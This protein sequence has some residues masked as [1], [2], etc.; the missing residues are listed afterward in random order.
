MPNNAIPK[1]EWLHCNACARSTDHTLLHVHRNKD[2]VEDILDEQGNR[3]DRVHGYN[4]WQLFECQG[5]KTVFL[6]LKEY[7]S[8][9]H[10]AWDDDPYK[11]TSFPARNVGARPKPYW[12]ETLSELD[13]LQGHFIL[14][15]YE[16]IYQLIE[17]QNYLAALLTS[18][19][20]L[21]TIAVE[22]GSG[23][24]RTFNEKLQALNEND[25]IRKSQ[26]AFL[27][28]A[29]YDSGSA[30]MHRSYNPSQAAVNYVIDAIEQLLYTIYIE[31][32]AVG[33][34]DTERPS[35]QRPPP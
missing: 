25:F 19:A 18:R 28:K 17:S 15:A 1:T 16:Q 22:H 32:I 20:L 29:I 10:D 3:I 5:C 12:F 34:L 26:I 31:P 23:D 13:N 27:D 9:W 14:V 2:I 11:Y 30:A 4:D 6:R 8:E 33:Q 24:R 35:R 21:E 7:F